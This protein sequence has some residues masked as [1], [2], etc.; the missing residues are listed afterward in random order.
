MDWWSR[1][2]WPVWVGE[3]VGFE[4]VGVLMDD[5]VEVQDKKQERIFFER[6]SLK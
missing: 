2:E 5:M 1:L 6:M 4:G 3:A